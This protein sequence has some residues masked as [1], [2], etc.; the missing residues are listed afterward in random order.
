LQSDIEP[1][2]GLFLGLFFIAVGASIDFKLVLTEPLSIAGWVGLLIVVKSAVMLLLGKVFKI[3]KE[4]NFIF[5][6][7]PEPGGRICVRP[8]F[9]RVTVGNIARRNNKHDDGRGGYKHGAYT[10]VNLLNERL[11]FAENRNTGN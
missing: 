5:S 8:V 2:K 9:V 4:Q 11:D 1:F 7:G 6:F 10:L 3:S